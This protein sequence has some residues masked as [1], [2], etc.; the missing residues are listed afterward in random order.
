MSSIQASLPLATNKILNTINDFRGVA[1]NVMDYHVEPVCV[2][3]GEEV[4]QL[5]SVFVRYIN[6][7]QFIGTLCK[8]NTE[9]KKYEQITTEEI[10]DTVLK[11]GKLINKAP[12]YVEVYNTPGNA[13]LTMRSDGV[14]TA[15]YIFPYGLL[16]GSNS[17]QKLERYTYNHS[18]QEIKYA[19]DQ[20][21]LPSSVYTSMYINCLQKDENDIATNQLYYINDIPSKITDEQVCYKIVPK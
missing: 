15:L 18:K 12:Y 7:I 1:E 6:G 4:K 9:T 14:D 19:A 16:L 10:P 3:N 20:T 11:H 13:F 8:Y 5:Y 2:N 21:D 17:T